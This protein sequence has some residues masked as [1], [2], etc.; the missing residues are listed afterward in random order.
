MATTIRGVHPSDVR[1]VARHRLFVEGAA[2]DGLDPTV[3]R[4]LT[5][6]LAVRVEP[7]GP[8]Y[9]VKSAA[10]A[11]RASHP[12]C[13]FLVDRDH[14]GDEE[15]EATWRDFPQADTSN[16]LIWR[17][18]ELENYFILPDYLA[19]SQYRTCERCEL[20]DEIAAECRRRVFL[21]AANL[22]IVQVR[23]ESKR[24]WVRAFKKTDGFETKEA[25][26]S[27]LLALPA[28][29]DAPGE[30]A[31]RVAPGGL[32]DRFEGVVQSMLGGE[33]EPAHG[34]GRWM[35]MVSGK[36]VLPSL[37]SRCFRVVD[38]TG[39]V[40]QGPAAVREVVRGLLAGPLPE[41]PEDF[42]RLHEL[43]RVRIER[44]GYHGGGES[45]GE[46]RERT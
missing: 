45:D 29:A 2:G 37:I 39:K 7:L 12:T 38:N 20:S 34:T 23:E 19:R 36:A 1:P 4:L 42:R 8:S 32:T 22:V 17:R 13:F 30:L 31:E 9:Y 6:D 28:F 18:R 21:D 27:K 14:R 35:A 15:V 11:L 5:R 43:L 3:L 33:E 44:G 41:Q 10:E 24:N 46:A 25:A 26:L 16:L 40:L